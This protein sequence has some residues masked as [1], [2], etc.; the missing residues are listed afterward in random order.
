MPAAREQQS[1]V[2]ER[3]DARRDRFRVMAM[4]RDGSPAF[5]TM[6]S[7]VD[8]IFVVGGRA[9]SVGVDRPR[10]VPPMPRIDFS[11]DER[12][13]RPAATKQLYGV[14]GRK[15]STSRSSWPATGRPPEDLAAAG[16][17]PIAAG[18]MS[19]VQGSRFIHRTG[20]ARPRLRRFG[21]RCCR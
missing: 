1:N 12:R 8:R 14:H 15:V 9:G 7:W 3:Q 16:S 17:R 11:S 5:S 2:F 6:P 4:K 20:R 13:R 18:C 21:L 19:Y 10:D